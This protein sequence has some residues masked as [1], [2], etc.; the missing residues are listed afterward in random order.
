[1]NIVLIII[2][3]IV[4]AL[5]IAALT[6]KVATGKSQQLHT[7]ILDNINPYLDADDSNTLS[8]ILEAIKTAAT[9]IKEVR[10]SSN[11][12]TLAKYQRKAEVLEA[13]IALL[14]EDITEL[15]DFKTEDQI[16]RYIK[17]SVKRLLLKSGIEEWMPQVGARF[18]QATMIKDG[19]YG[20]VI[21]SVIAPGYSSD[22][23]VI[24]KAKVRLR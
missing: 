16:K 8:T 21:D 2:G 6:M 20:T 12:A 5:P 10:T 4:I 22:G 14:V 7:E 17:G 13:N 19:E 11:T 9:G 23:Q 18:E 24:I 15:D 3:V 1:M